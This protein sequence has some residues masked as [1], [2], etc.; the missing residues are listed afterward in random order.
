M[1]VKSEVIACDIFGTVYQ[2]GPLMQLES[3]WWNPFVI[4]KVSNIASLD[5]KS[6]LFLAHEGYGKGDINA[7]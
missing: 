3:I 4:L 5:E 7:D 1:G 2:M 6:V